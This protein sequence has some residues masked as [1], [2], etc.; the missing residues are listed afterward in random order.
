MS[1]TRCVTP[2]LKKVWQAVK[3]MA[4]QHIA[5]CR[6]LRHGRM[7]KINREETKRST[8]LVLLQHIIVQL[9]SCILDRN[10]HYVWCR[11]GM[12]RYSFVFFT[13]VLISIL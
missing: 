5:Q 13:L 8:V 2:D 4:S 1:V 3:L 11:L 9:P 12:C 10:K 7:R 6:I